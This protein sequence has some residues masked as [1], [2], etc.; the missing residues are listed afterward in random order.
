[1]PKNL[2]YIGA[3]SGQDP[4]NS[5]DLNS[6]IGSHFCSKFIHNLPEWRQMFWLPFARAC[7][8]TQDLWEVPSSASRA[9][10]VCRR[11]DTGIMS[12]FGRRST[13][14]LVDMACSLQPPP[15]ELRRPGL[16]CMS[17]DYTPGIAE[18][19]FF[20]IRRQEVVNNWM[21]ATRG[22]ANEIANSM[23]DFPCSLADH[24]TSHP[25]PC[26]S[27]PFDF[28]LRSRVQARTEYRWP[29]AK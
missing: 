8:E 13:G 11:L 6:C 12:R 19:V 14:W 29:E 18:S 15:S 1:M 3:A 21:L 20:F 2:K 26:R 25:W 24:V 17:D 23:L 28:F 22:A 5:G 4:L 7:P 16:F 27:L 10:R 9:A